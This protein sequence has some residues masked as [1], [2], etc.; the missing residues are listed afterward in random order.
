MVRMCE[1]LNRAQT[2]HP[3][4]GSVQSA[5]VSHVPPEV[6]ELEKVTRVCVCAVTEWTELTKA[7]SSCADST[8]I[9]HNSRKTT[10]R[11]KFACS[12]MSKR[13]GSTDACSQRANLC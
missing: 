12:R 8:A 7:A 6:S 11:S 3:S 9:V 10:A 1:A 4:N 13:F 5:P 2:S